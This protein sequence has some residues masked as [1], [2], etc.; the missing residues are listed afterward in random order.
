MSDEWDRVTAAGTFDP[1]D[2]DAE[3]GAEV[4]RIGEKY[5]TKVELRDEGWWLWYPEEERA[6]ERFFFDWK[7]ARKHQTHRNVARE[8]QRIADRWTGRMTWMR[9]T[10]FEDT[11]ARQAIEGATWHGVAAG[12]DEDGIADLVHEQVVVSARS[13]GPWSQWKL[14]ELTV[15]HDATCTTEGCSLPPLPPKPAE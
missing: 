10:R 5:G 11:D 3:Y 14:D 8:K 2:V 7:M 12:R 13:L 1:A 15:A 6:R 9:N 4:Q